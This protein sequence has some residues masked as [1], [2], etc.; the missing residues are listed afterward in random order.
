ME[1]AEVVAEGAAVS[2]GIAKSAPVA[3]GGAVSGLNFFGFSVPDL[4][5]VLT[6]IYLAVTIAH[7]AWKWGVEWRMAR[8]KECE[9]R[10]VADDK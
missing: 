9:V 8:R 10:V 4:V 3:V 7:T 1:R 6:C 2:G 5:P